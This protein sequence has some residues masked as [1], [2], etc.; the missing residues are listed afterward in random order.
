MS[1]KEIGCVQ[2]PFDARS[3][4]NTCEKLPS[5]CDHTI[6]ASPSGC[7]LKA[8]RADA[9]AQATLPAAYEATEVLAR[10]LGRKET[11]VQMAVNMSQVV[12]FLK[13]TARG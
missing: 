2:T 6:A 11:V 4:L 7:L 5:D 8:G 13:E 12:E 3:D 9:V 10:W 1:L